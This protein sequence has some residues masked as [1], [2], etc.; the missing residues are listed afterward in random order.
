M[1]PLVQRIRTFL[2]SPRGRTLLDRGRRE[3]AKPSN[4]ER[5]RRLVG[6]LSGRRRSR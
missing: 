1:T 6:R 2:R 3:I 4:Q 5:L